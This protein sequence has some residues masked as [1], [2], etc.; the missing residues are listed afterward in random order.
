M[1][2]HEIVSARSIIIICGNLSSGKGTYVK[3][4]YPDYHNIT[5]SSVV[6]KI[7]GANKRSELSKTKSL[8]TQ[9]IEELIR[10]ISEY[11]KVVVEGIRQPS[12]LHK[13]KLH[14][15]QQIKDI[16][17]LDV[18]EE[19]R[20]EYFSKRAASKDDL[21]FEAAN[22]VDR[23]LGIDDLEKHIRDNHRVIKL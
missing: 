11:D 6:K 17:W 14:F 2:L 8:D 22:Q 15:G 19:K 10:E 9:I 4:Y 7:S 20:R 3:E 5:V 23:N 13:L 16:I 1:K 12:I 18:P 21:D